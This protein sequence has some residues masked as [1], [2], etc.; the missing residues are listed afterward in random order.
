MKPIV[1]SFIFVLLFFQIQ[2]EANDACVSETNSIVTVVGF[3][4]AGKPARQGLGVVVGREGHVLSS[5]T[6]FFTKRAGVVKTSVG[7]FLSIQD[8]LYYDLLQDLVLF[9]VNPTDLQTSVIAE[10][11]R[12]GPLDKVWVPVDEGNGF[13]LKE[14]Q[15]NSVLPLSPRLK[16]LNLSACNPKPITG[17]PIFNQKGAIVG[18][19]HSFPGNS[20]LPDFSFCLALD[21][22]HLAFEPRSN[23]FN[24]HEKNF[25]EGQFFW[26]GVVASNQLRW[27]LAQN[28]F[29][30]AL[31]IS[32]DL[33]EAFWGRG[34]ARYQLGDITGALLDLRAAIQRS[35]EYGLAYLWLG[36]ALKRQGDYFGQKMAFKRSVELCPVLC[37]GWFQLGLLAY[38]EGKLGQAK[39][40]LE[41]VKKDFSQVAQAWWYLGEIAYL[42]N[43]PNEALAAFREAINS[44]PLF[45]EAYLEGGKLLLLDSAEPQKAVF[46]LRKAV[47]VDPKN[48]W[49]RY[50]LSLAYSITWNYAGAW[51]QY[52][53]LREM[54]SDLADNLS[55]VLDSK[56]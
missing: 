28:K 41:R 40:Y 14:V 53:A 38:Q 55:T 36:K 21:K 23:D 15:I 3:D 17:T 35:P 11:N 42:Q 56:Y 19:W 18:L 10:V 26:E 20:E 48:C 43:R 25:T 9:K 27:Q 22:N 44:D 54:N 45:F 8:F 4:E 32:P 31:A 46:M 49:A 12:L 24:R 5:G 1:A 51:E 2:A 39:E 30:E 16:M 34:V 52:L 6:L 7:K 29:T 33:P 47:E 13:R 50:Y 37:E